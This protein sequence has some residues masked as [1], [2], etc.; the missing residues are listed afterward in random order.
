MSANLIAWLISGLLLL[1]ILYERIRDR[2]LPPGPARLPLIGNLHQA[3]T[4]LPWVTYQRWIKQYGPIISAQ[5]GSNTV[6]FIGDATIARSLLDKRGDIYSDRPRMVMAGENLTKGIHLLLRR[7]NERYKLHQRLDAPVLSL[8]ASKTYY[9]LQDLESKQLLFDFLPTNDFKKVYERYAASLVYSLVY[10][11][12]LH[13]G[14]EWMLKH[15]HQV[16]DNFAYAARVGTWIVDAIPILN[17][18][19]STLAPWKKTAEKFYQIEK[20]LHLNNMQTALA[21]KG[22]NWTKEFSKSKEAALMSHIELAYNV[23]ILADAGLDTT[24][25]QMRMFT[26][27]T[28]AYPE[29]VIKAQKELDSVVGPDRLPTLDDE[30]NLPY[31]SAIVKESLRWRS[32]APGGV[33]HATLTADEYMGYQIPKGATIVWLY[34]AMA[35]DENTFDRPLEF[36]PERWLDRSENEKKCQF[37]SFFGYGR[38]LCTGRHIAK[39]SLFLL[40]ARILWGFD[41]RHAVDEDGKPKEVDDLNMTSGFVSSPVPFEAV[42][43][44]RSVHHKEV[45]ESNWRNAEKDIDMIMNSIRDKQISVGLKVQA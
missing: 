7:Y 43:E 30:P 34:W 44:P 27:A 26:L 5:F 10:G 20:E 38:R 33:P 35:L 9:P 24:S 11:T 6:I 21:T 13:T 16:Q 15:A 32:I 17:Y 19:P 2:R 3:P 31:I 14:N 41:V 45:I 29:F 36:L 40:M 4:N 25:L 18:L 8:R 42:F 22:W 39:N 12:R 23:G 28:L 37:V 1:R